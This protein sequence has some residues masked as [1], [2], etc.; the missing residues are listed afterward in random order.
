M[1]GATDPLLSLEQFMPYRLNRAAETV[2]RRFA[3]IYRRHSGLTRPEWRALATLGQYGSLTATDIGRHSAMHKTKVSR[4]VQALE[5][6]R[7]LKR[8]TDSEDRRVEHLTLT[9][10]GQKNYRALARL[11]L[12]FEMRLRE[13]LGAELFDQLNAGMEAVEAAYD[14][15]RAPD[16][17]KPAALRSPASSFWCGKASRPNDQ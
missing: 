17:Q 11:A 9:A 15:N 16:K 4:A 8:Q 2:S 7:W 3:S 1:T 6:R 10:L 5:D 14:A 13:T 12:D